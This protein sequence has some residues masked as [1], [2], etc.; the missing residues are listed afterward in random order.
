MSV[1]LLHEKERE[2]AARDAR[3][4]SSLSSPHKRASTYKTVSRLLGILLP[5]LLGLL[6]LGSW[7]FS[8]ARGL[9]STYE[10]PAPADVESALWNGLSTGLF[11]HMGWVTIQESGGGFLLAVAIA[12]P[13]GY[14]LA[15]WRLFAATVYPYLVAGQAV[16][17]IVIAPFLVF[18]MGYG[19]G[20][21]VV[22]CF[23]VVLF[24]MVITTALGFSTLDR[25]LVDAARVEG[26][27]FWPLLTKI[28]FPLALPAI[29]AAVR[30]GLTLSIVGALVGEFVTGTDQ[31]LGALVQIARNGYNMPLMFATVLIMAVLAASYFAITWGLTK[32]SEAIYT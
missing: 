5:V 22:L 32:L 17:A 29:M 12:L 2:A 3:T 20:P 24:P 7:Y 8:T 1:S 11:L 25:L 13:V 23:F 27:S 6:L 21:T 10:L 31:G 14:S 16:P 15:K 9:V 19:M 4:T 30:T 26:A 18:W 28:E